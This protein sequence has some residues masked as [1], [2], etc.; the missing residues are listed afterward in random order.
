MSQSAVEGA[1]IETSRECVGDLEAPLGLWQEMPETVWRIK[2]VS[3]GL[4][5]YRDCGDEI[6]SVATY[7]EDD[8]LSLAGTGYVPEEWT[9]E[10][11]KAR[12]YEY[13]QHPDYL[14]TP[15]GITIR[16]GQFNELQR[17]YLR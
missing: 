14:G 16:D 13:E 7:S 15:R 12:Y 10:R 11:L 6:L 9:L 8:A 1:Q 2:R 5:W 17:I 3:D 4:Y